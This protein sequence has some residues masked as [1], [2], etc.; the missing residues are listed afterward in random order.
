MARLAHKGFKVRSV[1]PAQPG[2]PDRLELMA[3]MVP[4]G[5][6]GQPALEFKE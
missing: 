4:R 3:L 1:L 2:L 6:P 5:Q